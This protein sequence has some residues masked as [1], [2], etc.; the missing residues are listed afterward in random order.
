MGTAV[1]FHGFSVPSNL[2]LAKPQLQALSKGAIVT[3]SISCDCKQS[4]RQ[5]QPREDI[6]NNVAQVSPSVTALNRFKTNQHFLV[7]PVI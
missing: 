5:V 6:L 1:D 2:L 3:G 7:L 4:V